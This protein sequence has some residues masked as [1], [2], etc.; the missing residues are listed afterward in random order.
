M[1]KKLEIVFKKDVE[2]LG[3][4]G[5]VRQVAAGF[6]RNYLIPKGYAL[7]LKDRR[8][9]EILKQKAEIQ[10]AEAAKIDEL[11]NLAQKLEGLVLTIKAKV[12]EKGKLFGSI[13][14][15]E[16]VAQLKKESKI[17]LKKEQVECEPIKNVGEAEVLIKL[18]H[19]ITSKIKIV[20]EAEVSEK[21]GQKTKKPKH[22]SKAEDN[23][24]KNL[25]K[26]EGK[27]DRTN[28]PKRKS[29]PA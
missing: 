18:G 3:S 15:E 6:A 24:R 7:Y 12:G 26:S 16:I 20:V 23:I 17:E 1:K 22:A 19:Q 8:S 27:N 9:K 13:G 4:F 21:K 29:K 25:I 5:E 14:P 2:N 10:K 11:K 28:K